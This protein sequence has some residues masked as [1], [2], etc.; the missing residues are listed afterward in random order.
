[1]TLLKPAGDHPWADEPSGTHV[2]GVPVTEG[3]MGGLLP[4]PEYF[5]LVRT[6]MMWE[7]AT[8]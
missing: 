5:L 7:A 8:G 2:D 3:G 1:M 6:M 4:T